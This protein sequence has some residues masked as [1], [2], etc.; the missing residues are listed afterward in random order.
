MKMVAN[1]TVAYEHIRKKL[2]LRRLKPGDMVSELGLSKEI[3]MSRGPIREAICQL[4]SEGFIRKMEGYGAFIPVLSVKEVRELYR[5]RAALECMA[6]ADAAE[7]IRPAEIEK[8]LECC[9]TIRK[10]AVEARR[11]NLKTF[12]EELLYRY[13][14]ADAT[15]HMTII[16]A[17]ENKLIRRVVGDLHIMSRS[18]V[19]NLER[20]FAPLASLSL[21]YLKH[22]RLIRPFQKHDPQEAGELMRRHILDSLPE[23]L[24]GHQQW[25]DGIARSRLEEYSM[26]IADR[27]HRLGEMR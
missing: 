3:G 8:L 12:D 6:A 1:K 5:V 21:D 17:S 4:Q 20:E 27:I 13:L 10:L 9:R 24:T 25:L 23:V 16:D 18:L 11:R 22:Y 15:F 19:T 14:L 2:M 7:S 26:G